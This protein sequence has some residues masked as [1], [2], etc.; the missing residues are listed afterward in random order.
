MISHWAAAEEGRRW[1]CAG[2]TTGISGPGLECVF[3]L[4]Y[5]GQLAADTARGTLQMRLSLI[6]VQ[7]MYLDRGI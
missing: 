4:S 6:Q 7:S 2:D 1:W 5:G 3:T